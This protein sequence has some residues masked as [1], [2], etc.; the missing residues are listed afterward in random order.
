MPAFSSGIITTWVHA[1]VLQGVLMAHIAIIFSGL[2]NLTQHYCTIFIDDVY[3]LQKKIDNQVV[4]WY[5]H[6]C[7]NESGVAC[8]F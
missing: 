6:F 7:L 8:N 1:G 2:G 5:F 4:I 3:V